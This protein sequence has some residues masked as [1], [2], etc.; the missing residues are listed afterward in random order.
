MTIHARRD[1][2]ALPDLVF[3]AAADPSR[4]ASWLPGPHEVVGRSDDVL[5]LRGGGSVDEGQRQVQLAAD[6]DRLLLTWEPLADE[7]CRGELR[8]SLAGAAGSVAELTVDGCPDEQFAARFL[9]ALAN[10]VEQN[11]TAG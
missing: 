1:V 7:G 8:V 3:N 10:E 11:L 4:L 6:Y 5:I 9:E 2:P